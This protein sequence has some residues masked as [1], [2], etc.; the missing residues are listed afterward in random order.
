MSTLNERSNPIA[1]AVKL[2]LL[3]TATTVAFTPSAV[4]AAEEEAEEE[5][6]VIT[7]SR[8]RRQEFTAESPVTVV[9]SQQFELGGIVNTEDMINTLPQAI[10]GLDKTSNNPGNGTATI[11][12]RGLG[13]NRTLILLNG[14]RA[15]PTSEGGVVDINTIPTAL[16]QRVE[17]LTTRRRAAPLHHA[18]PKI[19]GGLSA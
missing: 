9:D 10:P 16:I 13:S 14:T 6:I 3:A 19:P 11:N 4:F 15:L 12:L 18:L 17:V 7:G 2:A 1:K 5:R 8:I